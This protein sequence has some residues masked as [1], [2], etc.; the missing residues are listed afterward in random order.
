MSNTLPASQ[1]EYDTQMRLLEEEAENA[2]KHYIEAKARYDRICD[3]MRVCASHGA[4]SRTP[5][6]PP[7]PSTPSRPNRARPEGHRLP[8]PHQAPPRPPPTPPALSCAPHATRRSRR[9]TSTTSPY[10]AAFKVH[11]DGPAVH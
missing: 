2:R 3:N 8:R 6:L 10:V 7:W 1:A 11:E 4:K 9:T 5:P